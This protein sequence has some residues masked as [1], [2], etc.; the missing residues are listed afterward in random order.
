MA[1]KLICNIISV[2]MAMERA[3]SDLTELTSHLND[4]FLA[5][6]LA[7]EPLYHRFIHWFDYQAS[8]ESIGDMPNSEGSEGHW[9]THGTLNFAG[10]RRSPGMLHNAK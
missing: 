3:T 9:P 10:L 1:H 2:M 7:D 8:R 4:I 5:Q 6:Y